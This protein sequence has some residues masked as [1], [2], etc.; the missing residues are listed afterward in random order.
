MQ[1]QEDLLADGLTERS[2]RHALYGCLAGALRDAVRDG[3]IRRNPFPSLRWRRQREMKTPASGVAPVPRLTV[4]EYAAQWLSAQPDATRERA[5]R[6]LDLW[7]LPAIGTRELVSIDARDETRVRNRMLEHGVRSFVI[8]SVLAGTLG[9]LWRDA[10]AEGL[11]LRPSARQREAPTAP[12][13]HAAAIAAT[14]KARIEARET[15]LAEF[16]ERWFA[17]VSSP[18]FVAAYTHT[19][20]RQMMARYIEPA[21][22]HLRLEEITRS[23]VASFQRDLLARRLSIR[24]VRNIVQGCLGPMLAEAAREELI[25]DVPTRGLRWP[26][27]D[28]EPPDALSPRDRERILDW[29]AKN[30]PRYLPYVGTVLLAGTRPSEAAGLQWGDIS[31]DD[32]TIHVQRAVVMRRV[33]KTKTAR[34][35]RLLRVSDRLIEIYRAAQPRFFEPTDFVVPSR[36]G[37]PLH[38]NGFTVYWW[39]RCMRDL[40][41][42]RRGRGLYKGRHGFISDAAKRAPLHEIAAYCGNSVQICE[43]HYLRW[44]DPI[45][46]PSRGVRGGAI[47]HLTDGSVDDSRRRRAGNPEEGG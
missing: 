33:G 18:P 20:R 38:T 28:P 7:I 22:G 4:A 13:R 40:G 26:R 29:F 32:R 47:K 5:R 44:I 3:L 16:G 27:E 45:R 14:R 6:A 17:T 37:G 9:R 36:R 25:P 41:L 31:F 21:L 42:Q 30:G 2:A 24:T 15:S 8:R 10:F 39:T 34:S 11:T 12:T 23:V 19:N 1:L 35:R 46:D 43:R